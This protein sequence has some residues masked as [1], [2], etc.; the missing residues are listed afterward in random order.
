MIGSFSEMR[1]NPE[2]REKIGHRGGE[3]REPSIR[4]G[5]RNCGRLVNLVFVKRKWG[6]GTMGRRT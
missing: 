3:R 1:E 5:T 6:G 2:T 4:M